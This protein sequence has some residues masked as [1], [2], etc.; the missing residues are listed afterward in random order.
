MVLA[1]DDANATTAQPK[2]QSVFAHTL[3]MN[4][5]AIRN[6]TSGTATSVSPCS[7]MFRFP[8]PADDFN[9][10]DS[11]K[12]G[13]VKGWRREFP[14]QERREPIRRQVLPEGDRR[15]RLH[16]IKS[17]PSAKLVCIGFLAAYAAC[18]NELGTYLSWEGFSRAS[19]DATAR[20]DRFPVD[21]IRSGEMAYALS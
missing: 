12:P 14:P 6:R 17:S 16:V 9:Q 5:R 11:R 4:F 7:G 10:F 3:G 1:L 13:Q 18:Y 21:L 19:A 2:F 8:V 20:C 15:C